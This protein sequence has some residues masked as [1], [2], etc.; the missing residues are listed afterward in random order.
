MD[1][2]PTLLSKMGFIFAKV[3]SCVKQ[4]IKVEAVD[5]KGRFSQRKSLLKKD[6]ASALQFEAETD[7]GA[8]G[9][10]PQGLLYG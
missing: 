7:R 3:F 9:Y 8:V 1:F 10:S 4:M 5:E 6:P 2:W